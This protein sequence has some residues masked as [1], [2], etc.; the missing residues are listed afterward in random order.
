MSEELR[1]AAAKFAEIDKW[2][3]EFEDVSASE[4]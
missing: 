3:M 2:E 1:A 4:V